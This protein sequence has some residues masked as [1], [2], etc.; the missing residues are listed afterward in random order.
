MVG[1]VHLRARSVTFVPM[2]VRR[3][4][5]LRPY[6]TFGIDMTADTFVEISSTEDLQ[7]F[8]AHPDWQGQPRLWLGGGSN[9]LF[10]RDRF[11]GVVLRVAIGGLAIVADDGECVH[12]RAGAG[13]VWHDL[14]CFCLDHD[15]QG[16]ENLSLIPGTVGAAPMQNIGAYGVELKETFVELTAVAVT[17]GTE[18]TFDRAACRFGYRDSVFKQEAKGQYVITSVTFALRRTPQFNVS[19]GAIRDTLAAQGIIELSARAI[20]AA[21]IQIRQ[22]KLP[23]PARTGN[24]GSFFKNPEIPNAAFEQLRTDYPAVPGFPAAQANH[25]K[26]PAGWLIERCGFKGRRFGAVGVH[27]QQ[28]LVLV[29][30]GGATGAEVVAVARQIQQTV[31]QRFGIDLTPEVNFV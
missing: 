11:E 22:S 23:D 18:R 26:V 1:K 14:V 8:L 15:L 30:L 20:S 9:V 28:A 5:S 19:Y 25:T 21:V 7:T 10:T 13:V 27:D 4:H 24:A 31:E 6:N 29:N 3:H 17:D 16:L 12:V 2:N